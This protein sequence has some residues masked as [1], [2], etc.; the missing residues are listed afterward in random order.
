M[1][2]DEEAEAAGRQAEKL[3]GRY[4]WGASNNATFFPG[5]QVSLSL[6]NLFLKTTSL[7]ELG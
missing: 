6:L 1:A 5:R 2:E 7:H 3:G 4:R